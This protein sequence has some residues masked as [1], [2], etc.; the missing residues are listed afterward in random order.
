[1]ATKALN[2][3]NYPAA[4]AD[5]AGDRLFF[6]SGADSEI[7]TKPLE[8]AQTI[9]ETAHGFAAGDVVGHDGANWVKARSAT[10][11][12]RAD[13]IVTAVTD[14]NTFTVAFAGFQ[15]ITAHGK[16]AGVNYLDRTTAG[17][18]TTTEPEPGI[19]GAVVQRVAKVIDANT[20]IVTIGEPLE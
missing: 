5:D 14:V 19:P 16:T 7:R 20:L 8:A 3:T 2:P 4:S 11:D 17:A 13:G 15:T 6:F 10:G 12:T 9:A 18:M 1:M